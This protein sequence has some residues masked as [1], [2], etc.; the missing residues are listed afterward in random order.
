MA[1]VGGKQNHVI[2]A[3]INMFSGTEAT[4]IQ[5]SREGSREGVILW[6]GFDG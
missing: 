5:G 4:Q 1:C 6:Q 3:P 2:S